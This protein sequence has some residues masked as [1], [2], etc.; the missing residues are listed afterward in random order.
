[1]T[2]DDSSVFRHPEFQIKVP[3]DMDG[4]PT[5]LEQLAWDHIEAE[6]YRGTLGYFAQDG[7]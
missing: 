4:E 2:L 3:R 1:M 6:D 7:D 5:E